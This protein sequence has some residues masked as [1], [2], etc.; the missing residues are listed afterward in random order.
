MKTLLHSLVAGAVLLS[1][2]AHAETYPSKPITFIVPFGPGS[3]TDTITRVAAQHLGAALKQ[4]V[5]VEDRPGANGGAR[6]ALRRAL[7][8]GRL[9]LVHE[10]QQS[11]CGRALFDEE[12]RL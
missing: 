2:A 6:G 5:V 11:A 10:H 7:G 3:G 8:A 12:R 1:L 9:H 4:S